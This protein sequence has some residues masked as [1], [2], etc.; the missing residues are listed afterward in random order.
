MTVY[1]TIGRTYTST[2][3]P[4]PRV[5]ARITAALGDAATVVDV[6]A[7]AG[8]YEPPTTVLA[9]EPSPTMIAQRPPGAAPAVRAVAEAIPLPDKSVDAA[10]AVLTIHHWTDLAA[11]LAELRRVARSR[12]VILTWDQTVA[13]E[14]WLLREYL[15]EAIAIDDARAV[16]IDRLADAL[17]AR[18][19]AV[20]VP[21]DCTDGFLA[22]YWRRPA[23]YLD[24]AVR[25]GAS[26]LAQTGDTRLRPGLARLEADLTS[27]T[28]TTN[29]ADL[30]MMDELDAGYRLLVADLP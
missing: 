18:V 10:M 24:P 14:F 8:S 27:G 13:R 12:V 9:V 20:P 28:W 15:P 5:A 30:L 2:R 16:P 19:E 4:D 3:R 22:A 29:H 7:G 21:H 11:G 1:D 26:G 25:A 17:D 23:A 6:G